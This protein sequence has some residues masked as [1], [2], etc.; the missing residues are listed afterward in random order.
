MERVA[1][2]EQSGDSG[3]PRPSTRGKRRLEVL[4]QSGNVF[5]AA[6]N[7]LS[8]DHAD[9]LSAQKRQKRASAHAEAEAESAGTAAAIHLTDALAKFAA[10]NRLLKEQVEGLEA[11]N[12]ELFETLQA[13]RADLGA[14]LPLA[15]DAEAALRAKDAQLEGKDRQIDTLSAGCAQYERNLITTKVEVN[16]LQAENLSL[17]HISEPTR[18]Y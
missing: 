8:T 7:R 14:V 4:N 15:R 5:E 13:S 2:S 9:A 1:G 10:V 17:I 6:G 3:G 16:T 18:P 12:A 11:E